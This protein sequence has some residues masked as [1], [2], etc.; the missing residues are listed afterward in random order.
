[1]MVCA[2]LCGGSSSCH[3]FTI[4]KTV[5][6]DINCLLVTYSFHPLLITDPDY[7]LYIASDGKCTEQ[8]TTNPILT[9]DLSM[10]RCQDDT[11]YFNQ[12]V[13]ELKLSTQKD[14]VFLYLGFHFIASLGFKGIKM[15]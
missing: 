12:L 13:S 11:I 10:L 7:D 8:R 2:A 1:M 6:A 15:S 14:S 4:N 5:N 9:W 3:A